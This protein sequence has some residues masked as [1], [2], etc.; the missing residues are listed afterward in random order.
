[1]AADVT[2]G[3]V[4]PDL[5]FIRM[6]KKS[7][8]DSL[9]KCMQCANCSVAC[10]LAPD[11][12]PFPRKEMIWAQ[13]GLKDKLISNPDVWL[14]HQCNDCSVQCPRGAKPGDVLAAIR[15]MAIGEFAFMKPLA[16]IVRDKAKLPVLFAIPTVVLLLTL[17]VTG[18]LFGFGEGDEVAFSKMFSIPVID[19]VFIPLFLLV[20]FAAGKGVMSFWGALE[21]ADAR[22]GKKRYIKP[23]PFDFVKYYILPVLGDIITHTRFAKCGGN[24]SRYTAHLGIFFGFMGLFLVANIDAVTHNL[25]F[26]TPYPMLSPPKF[27]GNLSA[28]ALGIGILLVILKRKKDEAE[29]TQVGSYA[30]WSLIWMIVAVTVTGIISEVTRLIGIGFVAYPVYFAHL[31]F[32]FCLFLYLPYSKLA[33]MV[34]RTTAMVYAKYTGRE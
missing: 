6:L 7:G 23:S 1:M 16:K 18:K 28:L 17:L 22:V 10:P 33:H 12:R 8:G 15:N 32:V 14:C 29:G 21:T 13:W 2:K 5:D 26:H 4:Q 11:S 30:D 3:T 9:K 19:V 27:I 34:Y 20:V 25:G 31:V 24:K